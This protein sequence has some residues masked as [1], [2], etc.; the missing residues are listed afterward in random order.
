VL[1]D[2]VEF[3][4]QLFLSLAKCRETLFV[5]SAFIKLKA[6]QSDEF[7]KYLAGKNV[8]VIARWQKRDLLCGA[9][10][11]SV[12]EFCKSQGWNFG[13]DLNLHGK[14]FLV[15]ESEIFLGSANLTQ[16]GLHL[17]LVGN[18]EFGTKISAES[19]DLD[20]IQKFIESEV[21]WIDNSLMRKL[22][23]DIEHSV[24]EPALASS[25]WSQSVLD[26]IQK[27]IWFLWVH[28]LIFST[29]EDLLSPNLDNENVVHDLDLLGLTID[30]LNADTL[31]LAFKRMRLFGWMRTILKIGS[32]S[33]GGI[34][35]KLHSS[36]LDDPKPYRIDIKNYN[37]IIFEWARFINDVFE[38]ERPNYSQVLSLKETK[39]S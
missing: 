7:R 10:D 18:H 30:N 16:R 39:I 31:K 6:L 13:V 22:K 32:S 27:P 1:L 23:Y 37:K 12:Y 35:S 20:K 5:C 21:T 34:S 24:N 9:S 36:I 33:F 4:K 14:I 8:T 26:I 19:A 3:S 17:G 28:E 38:I 25:S 2:G 29:P 15:D 11:L